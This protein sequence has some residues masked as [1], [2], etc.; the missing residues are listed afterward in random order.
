MQ[1]SSPFIIRAGET[2]ECAKK[3]ADA[4]QAVFLGWSGS[5]SV[6]ESNVGWVCSGDA[7]LLGCDHDRFVEVLRHAHA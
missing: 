3:T 7:S 1:S 6:A 2:E 4:L 5:V